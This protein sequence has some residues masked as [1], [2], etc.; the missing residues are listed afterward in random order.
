MSQNVEV[1]FE[2][3]FACIISK[4]GCFFRQPYLEKVVDT[5]ISSRLD[6][7][8][9]LYA[10]L[11]KRKSNIFTKIISALFIPLNTGHVSTEYFQRSS[12]THTQIFEL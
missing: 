12:L 1:I 8:Y 9:F 2:K 4:N 3:H 6:Y 11:I 10:E 7:R 5:A